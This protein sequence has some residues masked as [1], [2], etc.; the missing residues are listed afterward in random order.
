MMD[1]LPVLP[2]VILTVTY[3]HIHSINGST[4]P[5]PLK[6]ALALNSKSQSGAD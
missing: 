6:Y 3:V 4:Y 2:P 1:L 5:N